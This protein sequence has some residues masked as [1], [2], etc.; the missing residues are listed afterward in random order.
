MQAVVRNAWRRFNEPL[1]GLTSWMYLDIK[2]FVTTGMASG[3]AKLARPGNC[4]ERRLIPFPSCASP[5]VP[6]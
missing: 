5:P 6:D 2:G 3:M 4:L 1:E